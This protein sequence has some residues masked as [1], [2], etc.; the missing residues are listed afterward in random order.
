MKFKSF[1]ILILF[2]IAISHQLNAQQYL[3]YFT[4]VHLSKNQNKISW[5]NPN[6]NCIQL[7]VQRST[8]SIN[9]FRTI[10]SAQ[11]PQLAENG[12][13]DKK[14]PEDVQLY[15]RI[16]YTLKG[17]EYFFSKTVSPVELKD[18][19]A[20]NKKPSKPSNK[21]NK[22]N[23]K[24]EKSSKVLK[25]SYLRMDKKG[26]LLLHLSKADQL[27]YSITFFSAEKNKLFSIDPIPET[28][29]VIEKGNFLKEGWFEYELKEK[30]KLIERKRFYI[31]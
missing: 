22:A 24:A 11:S 4:V 9:N 26:N 17:G 7:S 6:K 13:I 10:L 12:F 3:P 8:D 15:Y 28:E 16:F 25:S 18:N 19:I 27:N 21:K 5:N 23:K 29:L 20:A 1:A 30:G 2:Q 14:A 31:Q